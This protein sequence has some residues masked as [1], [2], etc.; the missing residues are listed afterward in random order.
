MHPMLHFFG[1]RGLYCIPY[2]QH[3]YYLSC[4]WVLHINLIIGVYDLLFM[5]Y[6]I[7][8]T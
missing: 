8:V 7:Y 4:Q 2:I 1:F 3:S 6:S 5:K